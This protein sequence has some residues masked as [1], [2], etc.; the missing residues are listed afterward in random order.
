MGRDIAAAQ[1]IDTIDTLTGFKYIS[2]W[3]KDFEETGDRSFLFG[4]EES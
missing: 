4:Y 3:I 1:G 2:A